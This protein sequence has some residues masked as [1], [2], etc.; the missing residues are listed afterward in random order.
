MKKTRVSFYFFAFCRFFFYT[1]VFAKLTIRPARPEIMIE[2]SI[3]EEERWDR[4]L[5]QIS[6]RTLLTIRS[7]FLG[8]DQ[9]SSHIY[10]YH[11]LI[12]N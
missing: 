4:Y 1:T 9:L 8:G 11:N 12:V 5:K 3:R 10:V 6:L 7:R 2:M